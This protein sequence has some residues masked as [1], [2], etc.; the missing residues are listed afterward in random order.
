[1]RISETG[2]GRYGSSRK[3]KTMF[4]AKQVQ[5]LDVDK[6]MEKILENHDAK[7]AIDKISALLDR[8]IGESVA[9]KNDDGEIKS[10]AE[11][12]YSWRYKDIFE[13]VNISGETLAQ[14]IGYKVRPEDEGTFQIVR[15]KYEQFRPKK[16]GE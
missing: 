15:D 7:V 2:A 12:G 1:M 9:E 5:T 16:E 10:D 13:G 6:I 11:K 8:K 3:G 4:K 14:I